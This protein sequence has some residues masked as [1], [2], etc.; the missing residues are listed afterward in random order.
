MNICSQWKDKCAEEVRMWALDSHDFVAAEACYHLTCHRDVTTR[1]RLSAT[2]PCIPV[3]SE[4]SFNCVCE[5]LESYSIAEVHKKMT[6][7]AN[8]EDVYGIK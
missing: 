7:L 4:S 8:D 5:W 2:I 3:V 6:E 1:K